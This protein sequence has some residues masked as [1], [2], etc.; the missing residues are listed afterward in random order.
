MNFR[1]KKKEEY[2]EVYENLE[3]LNKLILNNIIEDKGKVDKEDLDKIKKMLPN[4]TNENLEEGGATM[5]DGET[6]Y[7]VLWNY[8]S[9]EKIML[10]TSE[11]KTIKNNNINTR[12]LIDLIEKYN[13]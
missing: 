5:A 13:I 3:E 8:D 9:N 10:F 6:R 12:E 4:I 7:C 2:D 1:Q 11:N